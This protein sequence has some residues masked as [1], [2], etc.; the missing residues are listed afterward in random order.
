MEQLFQKSVNYNCLFFLRAEATYIIINDL[1][2]VTTKGESHMGTIPRN[3][4]CPCGSGKKF[5]NCC[6]RLQ[7]ELDKEKQTT[8]SPI[9]KTGLAYKAMSEKKWQEAVTMF[10]ECLEE[11]PDSPQILQAIASCYD[12]EEDFLRAAEFYEKTLTICQDSD[13]PHIFYRLGVARACA[14]RIEKAVEAFEQA[15]KSLRNPQEKEAVQKILD[16]LSLIASGTKP[17]SSFLS[18]VQLQR[19]FSDFEDED[20]EQAAI[21]LEKISSLDPS[22]PAIYYNLGVACAFLKREDEALVCFQKTIDLDPEYVTAYYNMG[23]IYLIAKRDFSQALN[24]FGRAVSVKDNYVGAHHQRG[25][26]YELLGDKQKA[27][28]C[29]RKT[30]DLDPG[31]KQALEN[32][33]R[34]MGPTEPI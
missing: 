15:I 9:E 13:K 18:Q 31:N 3:A 1:Q 23:Q 7:F 19:A 27:I 26:A 6:M 30:L 33:Q 2:F 4:P 5:K 21:R 8:D 25:I 16:E 11:Q 28:Q 20:Y 32:L 24:Y 17:V 10:K 22:N 14:G 12:G 29:W 34:V